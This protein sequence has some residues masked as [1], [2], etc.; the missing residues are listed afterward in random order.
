VKLN[1]KQQKRNARKERW[2][3][4]KRRWTRTSNQCQ[5]TWHRNAKLVTTTV[6]K[7]PDSPWKFVFFCVDSENSDSEDDVDY[8]DDWLLR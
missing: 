8:F 7:Q 3:E 6:G 5:K 1:K 4:K 2:L